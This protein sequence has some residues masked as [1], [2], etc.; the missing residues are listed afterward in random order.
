[1]LL[2]CSGGRD[3][4][5]LFTFPTESG[6]D[7]AVSDEC[8]AFSLPLNAPFLPPDRVFL[9]ACCFQQLSRLPTAPHIAMLL[10]LLDAFMRGL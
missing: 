4:Q 9:Q 2:G 7:P 10:R 5:P 8:G 1:M 3:D 6:L